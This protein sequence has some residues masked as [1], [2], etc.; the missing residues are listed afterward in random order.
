MPLTLLLH[1]QHARVPVPYQPLGPWIVPWRFDSLEREYAALRAGAGLIDY[2]TR[3]LIEVR[4]ADR[5]GFLQALLT[6]DVAALSPGRGCRAALLDPSARLIA[7]LVVWADAEAYWL[8]CDLDRAQALAQT[9]ERYHF[10]ERVSLTHHE[11]SQ[12]ALALQ[13]PR[14]MELLQEVTHSPVRLLANGDHG[15]VTFEG[16]EMRLVCHRLTA[17]SG[18]VCLLRAKDALAMWEALERRGRPLGLIRVG[19]EALNT[20]RIEDG[21]PWW[22]IDMTSANLLPETG[23][24]ALLVSDTKGCYLGQE[25][26]ARMRTYGS[27]N[28]RLM[29]LV[30]EGSDVPSPGDRIALGAE[31]LGEVTSGCASVA[32]KRPIAMGYVKRGAYEPGTAVEILHG[33]RRLC[34]TVSARPLVQS[35]QT[36]SA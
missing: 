20:A 4:G 25:I 1:G 26:I 32:L 7:E 14:T 33:E 8:M 27:P 11:R 30:V 3:A 10:S 28:K 2:S 17:G 22:G 15:A 9:L 6:N 24:D 29:G 13:G 21:I 12:A 34:A 18:V 31:T 35:G 16:I 36:R 19:W 5:A 23:L